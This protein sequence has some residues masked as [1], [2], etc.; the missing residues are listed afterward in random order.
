[1]ATS[2][3]E[4]ILKAESKWPQDPARSNQIA[5]ILVSNSLDKEALAITK[6]T[7]EQFPNNYDAWKVYSEIPTVSAREKKAAL[8]Q[9]KVL[10]PLN[11]NLK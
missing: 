4:S 2:K 8:E 1:M 10:D 7:V 11:P 9:M 3:L 5:V 6:K